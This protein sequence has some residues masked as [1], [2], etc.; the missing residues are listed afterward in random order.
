MTCDFFAYSAVPPSQLGTK[1]PRV[2]GITTQWC[3]STAALRDTE[4]SG[5]FTLAFDHDPYNADS[6]PSV[7]VSEG[8]HSFGMA[9]RRANSWTGEI[10]AYV[11]GGR[12]FEWRGAGEPPDG[13]YPFKVYIS[14]EVAQGIAVCEQE[15]VDDFSLAWSYT[16]GAMD[17]A[18]AQLTPQAS[19]GLAVK[20]L[21]DILIENNYRYV[22][23]ESPGYL[24]S[25]GPQ[26]KKA[27][28][29]LGDHSKKRDDRGEHSPQKYYLDVVDN[30]IALQFVLKDAK[31]D[32]RAYILP[33]E[34]TAAF[35][36]A[37]FEPQNVAPILPEG[38]SVTWR[39]PSVE[40]GS[41][42]KE[43]EYH[44]TPD[45]RDAYSDAPAIKSAI[46]SG[47][48]VHQIGENG[49]VKL[50]VTI[51]GD[52]CYVLARSALLVQQ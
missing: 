43:T 52:D 40:F 39:D 22:I 35:G 15:H 9:I 11:S 14:P 13:I 36:A 31:P 41:S 24:S 32:S 48:I 28:L 7:G 37:S 4:A 16:F 5:Q 20:Q 23:P 1:F 2:L 26:L 50:K 33:A 34:L 42:D 18:V 27:Y 29:D 30:T 25:W 3:P 17:W 6:H 19:T 21:V 49:Y 51:Y 46:A 38:A 45:L 10:T 12:L 44:A 47:A 8:Y